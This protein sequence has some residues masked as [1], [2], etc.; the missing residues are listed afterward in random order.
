M[1]TLTKNMVDDSGA[2]EETQPLKSTNLI[3][4]G[5]F[6]WG[7]EG[8]NIEQQVL[9]LIL[10]GNYLDCKSMLET[11]HKKDLTR[12]NDEAEAAVNEMRRKLDALITPGQQ[13]RGEADR[14]HAEVRRLQAEND[15]LRGVREVYRSDPVDE[16]AGLQLKE[17]YEEKP[18]PFLETLRKKGLDDIY[19]L[20]LV[21]K[22]AVQQLGTHEDSTN[23]TKVAKLMRHHISESWDEQ[24]SL[25]ENLDCK[26]S[27][28]NACVTSYYDIHHITGECIVTYSP[29]LETDVQKAT[30]QEGL[31]IAVN[32]KKQAG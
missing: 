12:R 17:F 10:A 20:G 28:H 26:T 4:C 24:I 30:T 21:D 1:S 31:D 13:K 9:E 6:D 7:A 22:N 8:V 25:R 3:E 32:E 27:K 29:F 11:L 19:M 5:A 2:D 23:H 15:G 14:W 16:C 18:F